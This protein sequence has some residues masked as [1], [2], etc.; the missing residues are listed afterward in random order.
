MFG[1]RPF[2][3]LVALGLVHALAAPALVSAEKT[4]MRP[5]FGL[6]GVVGIGGDAV[7]EGAVDYRDDLQAT[8]GVAAEV[9]VPITRGYSIGV[10]GGAHAWR[11]DIADSLEIDR[12]VLVD[13]LMV[14]RF[15]LAWGDRAS[16]GAFYF[17]VPIGATVSIARDGY[18]QSVSVATMEEIDLGPGGG[19]NVGGRLGVQVFF[20]KVFGFTVEAGYAYRLLRHRVETVLGDDHARIR[21]GQATLQGGLVFAFGP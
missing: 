9:E 16:H 7:I 1:M 15:R 17:A 13:L 14:N 3:P 10:E 2:F 21:F 4:F 5:R 11:S 6:R 20:G 18:A 8:A 12:N 19:L